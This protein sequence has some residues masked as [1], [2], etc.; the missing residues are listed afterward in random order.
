MEPEM[1]GKRDK[2]FNERAHNE[3]TYKTQGFPHMDW[4]R[5]KKRGGKLSVS[6]PACETGS[7]LR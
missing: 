5:L 6:L 2:D 4:E 7:R 1:V 3:E